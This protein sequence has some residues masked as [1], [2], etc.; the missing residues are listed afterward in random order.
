MIS[1]DKD[2]RI[3]YNIALADEDAQAEYDAIVLTPYGPFT[4]EVK[5]WGGEMT[6]DENGILRREDQDI[7]Y[8]LPGRMSVKEGLLRA[9]L[10]DLFPEN[11]HSIVLFANENAKVQDNYKQMPVCYGG[12][13]VYSIRAFNK[14]EEVLT[15]SQID[16]IVERISSNHKEQKAPCKVNCEEIIEDYAVLMAAIEEAAEGEYSAVEELKNAESEMIREEEIMEK[17]LNIPE[18]LIKEGTAKEKKISNAVYGTIG[19][20][21]A[22]AFGIVAAKTITRK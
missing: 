12:G 21:V 15:V 3:L 13:I 22:F 19:F 9:C 2:V 8:D 6:I 4:V 14:G 20:L 10:G 18:F 1:F 5:N 17:Q 7:K 16:E 11:Y